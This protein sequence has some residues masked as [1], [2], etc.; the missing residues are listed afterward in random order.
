M[1]EEKKPVE[2]NIVPP[3]NPADPIVIFDPF[4]LNSN[5]VTMYEPS[6]EDPKSSSNRDNNLLRQDGVRVPLIKLNN[7]S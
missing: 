4:K 6:E 2:K 7:T 1:A 3:L 5:I